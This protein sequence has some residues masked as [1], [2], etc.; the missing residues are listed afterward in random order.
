M[1][2]L[3][4]FNPENDVRLGETPGRTPRK[5]TQNVLPLMSDGALLPM[6]WAE[7][8]DSI[9]VR[10]N[11][12]PDIVLQAERMRSRFG[13]KG[14]PVF[15]GEKAHGTPVG[16]PWGWSYDSVRAL[17]AAG[18]NCPSQQEVDRMRQLSHRRTAS[19]IAARLADML[20]FPIPEPATECSSQ[21]KLKHFWQLI[22]AAS[23][24][25]PGRAADVA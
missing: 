6:W 12:N 4:L 23:L 7:D 19:E 11:Q 25:R 5:L 21:K 1:A 13:L 17:T 16:E 8:G 14:S 9:L 22:M 24:K 15:N 2:R 3:L 20:P 10:E 18:A